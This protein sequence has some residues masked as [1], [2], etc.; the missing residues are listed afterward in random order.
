MATSLPF[1]AFSTASCSTC[2]EV[3][4]CW[5]SV[6]GPWNCTRSPSF[7]PLLRLITATLIRSK[8]WVTLPICFP[9]PM[10]VLLH[11][12]R[13]S[14]PDPILH[15]DGCFPLRRGDAPHGPGGEQEHQQRQAVEGQVPSGLAAGQPVERIDH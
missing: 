13:A 3:I 6:C 5:K 4:S 15:P 11:F 8:K 10:A 12:E 7:S 9:S 2:M 14:N 1:L